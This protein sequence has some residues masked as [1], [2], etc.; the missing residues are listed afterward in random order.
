[1]QVYV[2]NILP[3][4]H[5]GSCFCWYSLFQ[6]P[7]KK[8]K[9]LCHYQNYKSIGFYYIYSA[10]LSEPTGSYLMYQKQDNNISTDLH[11]C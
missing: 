10:E 6:L 5:C 8:L 7:I 9:I 1:M 3:V 11:I 4:Y 2:P